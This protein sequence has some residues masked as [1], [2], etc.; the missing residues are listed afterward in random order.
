MTHGH[1][2]NR[3]NVTAP[4]RQASAILRFPRGARY[5][6]MIR[7]KLFSSTTFSIWNGYLSSIWSKPVGFEGHVSR[8][9]FEQS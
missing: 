8:V 6:S 3:D 2:V 7:G 9:K 5:P 4:K 1:L